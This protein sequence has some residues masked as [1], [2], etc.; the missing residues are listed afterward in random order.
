MSL[1]PCFVEVEIDGNRT[2]FLINSSIK[3]LSKIS[4]L[5]AGGVRGGEHYLGIRPIEG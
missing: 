4:G 3:G 5:H 1:G 2:G